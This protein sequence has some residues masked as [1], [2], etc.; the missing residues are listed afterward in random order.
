MIFIAA[1]SIFVYNVGRDSW[2][3]HLPID[4]KNPGYLS[5]YYREERQQGLA[6]SAQY[7]SDDEWREL[8]QG[9]NVLMRQYHYCS[10]PYLWI[11]PCCWICCQ[12]YACQH[13]DL[14]T[15]DA[16]KLPI[17]QRL[18]ARGIHLQWTPSEGRPGGLTITV[19]AV[20]VPQGM[21]RDAPP[22]V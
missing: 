13:G 14:V 9:I 4:R 21:Q 12:V 10:K 11:I 8:A 5:N 19:S 20:P 18:A 22:G 7:I 17:A 1:M 3:G 16:V 2:R 15:Q 6:A